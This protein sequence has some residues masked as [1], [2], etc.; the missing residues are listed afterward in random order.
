MSAGQIGQLHHSSN[1]D[2]DTTGSATTPPPNS[3]T[4][5]SWA[6]DHNIA[7]PAPRPAI[8]GPEHYLGPEL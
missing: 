3:P 6:I 5:S 7:L 4:P 1:E 8:G 2:S